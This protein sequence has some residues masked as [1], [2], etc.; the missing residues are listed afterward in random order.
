MVSSV[1]P[2]SSMYLVYAYDI[3]DNVQHGFFISHSFLTLLLSKDLFLI[4]AYL[5]GCTV[6]LCQNCLFKIVLAVL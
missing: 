1:I 5:I 4:N 3:S 2:A 6:S